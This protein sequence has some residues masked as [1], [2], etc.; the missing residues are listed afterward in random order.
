MRTFLVVALM[1]GLTLVATSTPASADSCTPYTA[2]EDFPVG[3]KRFG[4]QMWEFT[5]APQGEKFFGTW[6]P[7]VCAGLL[8][9]IKEPLSCHF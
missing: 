2:L 7:V 5:G 9:C 4:S 8:D 1:S 3:F 6:A